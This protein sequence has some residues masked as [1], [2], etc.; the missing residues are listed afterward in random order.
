MT[1][2]TFGGGTLDLE[3]K[4]AGGTF[5]KAVHLAT[6]TPIALTAASSANFTLPD[7]SARAQQSPARCAELLEDSGA[8]NSHRSGRFS[9]MHKTRRCCPVEQQ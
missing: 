9:G 1:D 3:V 2:G 6:T 4:A 5:L 8:G 7:R